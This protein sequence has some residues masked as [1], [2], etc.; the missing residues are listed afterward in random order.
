[1][2]TMRS[3]DFPKRIARQVIIQNYAIELAPC[4]FAGG[5]AGFQGIADTP[6]FEIL[7]PAGVP[8]ETGW[9]L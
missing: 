7:D 4:G 5:V 9:V 2:L 1:M 6:F 3:V 8:M